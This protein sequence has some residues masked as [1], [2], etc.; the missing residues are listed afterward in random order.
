M[1]FSLQDKYT[2]ALAEN[3]NIRKRLT[4]QIEEAKLFA[5]QKFC[6]D[7]LDVSSCSILCFVAKLVIVFTNFFLAISH[8]SGC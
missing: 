2:R 4:K 5:V 1:L 3:E 7:L 6:K 8:C